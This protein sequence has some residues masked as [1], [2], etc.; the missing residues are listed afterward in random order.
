MKRFSGEF[1]S[2]GVISAIAVV[3]SLAMIG[4]L[5]AVTSRID[6]ASKAREQ[7]VIAH[8]LDS[9]IADLAHRVVP[10]ANWDD[11]VQHLDLAFDHEWAAQNIGAY[12]GGADGFDAALVL[13]DEDAPVYGWVDGQVRQAQAY[14][15]ILS[16][17]ADALAQV[18]AAEQAR[19]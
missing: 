6:E 12:L 1:G 2:F 4:G 8:G 9:E 15:S 7:S 16:A 14:Q 5:F 19:G 10:Q 17:G 3:A 11:A 18:R 13:N